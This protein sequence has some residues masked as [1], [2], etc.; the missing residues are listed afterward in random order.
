MQNGLIITLP[1]CDDAT[2]YLTYYSKLV[3]KE[4]EEKWIK[5]KEIHDYELNL[6]DFIKI[7]NKLDYN[8][9]VFNGHGTTSSILGHKSNVILKVGV[10]EE[11]MKDR[12][13]YARSCNAA[14][15]LGVECTKNSNGAFIGYI[16]PFVFYM[17]EQWSAK[18][19]NDNIAKLFLEPSNQIPISL[20]KGNSAK[21][22]D[23][24]SKKH[25]LKNINKILRT[26]SEPDTPFI[27]EG[28]WNNYL[29]QVVMGNGSVK[30]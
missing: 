19:L 11:L 10:N 22:S 5:I 30:I 21:E 9:V 20:I 26:P 14:V 1:Q 13:I 29:G 28:L 12:I 17:N 2:E 18:P 15:S 8:F 23:I 24:N 7:I 4:A 16:F 6:K 25:I 3:T 27:V